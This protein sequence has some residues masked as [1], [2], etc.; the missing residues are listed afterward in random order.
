MRPNRSA[1][2][3]AAAAGALFAGLA[4]TSA[5]AALITFTWD[6]AAISLSTAGPFMDNNALVA[7][8]SYIDVTGTG[9]TYSA[10][11]NSI[12][13]ITNFT[14][15]TA[16]QPGLNGSAGAT[17]Y[18]LYLAITATATL[19]TVI[20][21]ADYLGQFNTLTYTFYG[22]G[23]ST[24]TGTIL[25]PY[26]ICSFTGGSGVTNP[27]ANC[28]NGTLYTL[29]TGGLFTTSFGTQNNAQV[30]LGLPSSQ[31]DT[32]IAPD[33]TNGTFFVSPPPSALVDFLVENQEGQTP[34]ATTDTC[35]PLGPPCQ[36]FIDAGS[37]NADLL[38]NTV[39]EP[40]TLAMFGS[41]L[42]LLGAFGWRRRKA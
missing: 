2:T 3:A 1:L 17:P 14:G 28:S 18:Y 5:N 36:I 13:N 12:F 38:G 31:V 24:A 25:N 41:A 30:L 33:G 15:T 6:P 22:Y 11:E 9:P 4:A 26:A 19:N 7:Q 32:T 16:V 20:P 42:M 21:G 34:G 27:A 29:A 40:G 8:Y 39:P 23:N 35:F 10:T 37:G